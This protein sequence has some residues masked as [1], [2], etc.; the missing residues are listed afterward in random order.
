MVEFLAGILSGVSIS[1]LGLIIATIIISK[2]ENKEN[3]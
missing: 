1:F 2:N 3:K